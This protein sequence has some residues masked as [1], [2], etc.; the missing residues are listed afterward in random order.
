MKWSSRL[1]ELS[2]MRRRTP[3]WKEPLPDLSIVTNAPLCGC[4]FSRILGRKTLPPDAKQFPIGNSHK[5]GPM[6]VSPGMLSDLEH[7]SGKKT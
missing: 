1:R 3:R 2:R 5:Q 6:L 7:L 4:G